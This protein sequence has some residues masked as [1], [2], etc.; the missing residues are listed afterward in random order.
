MLIKKISIITSLFILSTTCYSGN[1]T[2]NSFSKSK[3]LLKKIY[4][5]HQITFY[6]SCKYNYK[7]KNNMIDRKSCGYSPRN[8]YTKSG[9]KNIRARRIEWEHIIP[10]ENFGRQFTCWREGDEACVKTSGKHYKGRRCC[11]K[12]NKKFKRMEADLHNLVPAIGEL[13]ADRS[14]FRYGILEGEKRNY[15][16]NIDFE[17]DKK[18]RV[19][20][21]KESI[22][23]D[24]ARVYFY[25]EKEYGMKI[26]KKDK[27]IFEVWNNLDPVD[28]WEKIKN[29][30][31]FKIQGNR[32]EFIK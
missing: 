7:N 16:V 26:S 19:T 31:V 8:E 4:A 12:V 11:S 6:S 25:F 28:E 27:K 29:E 32:N 20:E 18:L 15:G 17:V 30:K 5:E 14:N 9:K 22:R 2:I 23:G 21:P 13:N 24:I 1:E 3:K 10:A